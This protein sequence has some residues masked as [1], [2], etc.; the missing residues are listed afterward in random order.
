MGSQPGHVD[1]AHSLQV[2][3]HLFLQA[4]V[5]RM[6]IFGVRMTVRA[7]DKRQMPNLLVALNFPT[8]RIGKQAITTIIGTSWTIGAAPQRLHLPASSSIGGPNSW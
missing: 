2:R 4:N 3:S 1:E 6:Q 5:R 7:S 8:V